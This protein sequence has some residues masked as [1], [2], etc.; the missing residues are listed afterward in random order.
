M[1][2]KGKQRKKSKLEVKLKWLICLS[3]II[4]TYLFIDTFATES[5][6]SSVDES[7]NLTGRS[8]NLISNQG[9][10]VNEFKTDTDWSLVL[11]NNKNALDIDYKPVLKSLPNGLK[12]DERAIGCLNEMLEAAKKE[13]L[14]PIV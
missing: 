14:S 9:S 5:L 3:F 7:D 10:I 13:G 12:F 1:R 11:V 8:G 4:T 2:N 6:L